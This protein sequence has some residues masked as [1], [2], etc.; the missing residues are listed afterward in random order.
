MH[1]QLKCKEVLITLPQFINREQV[2]QSEVKLKWF[3]GSRELSRLNY[4]SK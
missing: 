3:D 2:E 4:P 1:M